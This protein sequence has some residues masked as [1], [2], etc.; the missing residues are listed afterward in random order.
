M[1]SNRATFLNE[2]KGLLDVN[3]THPQ[4]AKAWEHLRTAQTNFYTTGEE[5]IA[6]QLHSVIEANAVDFKSFFDDSLKNVVKRLARREKALAKVEKCSL[7]FSK[8]LAKVEKSSRYYRVGLNH[9]CEHIPLRGRR[10][11]RSSTI[12]LR[13]SVPVTGRGPSS[14]RRTCPAWWTRGT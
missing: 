13:H 6:Q 2:L 4:N 10:L 3:M 8:E 11:V 1:F 5:S 12:T 7:E 14:T 9:S